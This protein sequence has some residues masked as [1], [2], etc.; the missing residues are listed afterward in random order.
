MEE[1]DLDE[2]DD[3]EPNPEPTEEELPPIPF[4]DS[5]DDSHP[6]VSHTPLT[7]G[8]S[9]PAAPKASQPAPAPAAKPQIVLPKQA[10]LGK[11]VSG[12]V[13]SSGNRITGCK[14]FFA[15]LHAGAVE[16]LSDQIADWIKENPNV[17]IKATSTVVGEVAA[18]KTEPNL[19]ITVWY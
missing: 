10:Q 11:T 3:I 12:P 9:G 14:I 6:D 13:A 15:K 2:F 7:L 16:F 4:D 19:I 18:K 1:L 17:V 5:D 8:S